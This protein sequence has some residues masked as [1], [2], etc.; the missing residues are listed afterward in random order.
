[1]AEASSDRAAGFSEREF[2][3]RE[4]RGRTL[5]LVVSRADFAE[6]IAPV[7]D[8]LSAGGARAIVVARDAR[9]LER[10]EA[11]PALTATQP[12]LEG[13]VWR[14]LHES[15]R[16]GIVVARGDDFGD[17][18]RELARRLGV[19]KLV[20]LDPAGGLV[21]R[22]G[23]RLSFVHREELAELLAAPYRRLGGKDRLALW[24]EIADMLDAGLPAVN[25]CAPEGLADELFTYAGSGTLFTRERYMTVRALGVD[26][27]DAAHDLLRRGVDEGFLAPRDGAE[28]DA[29]LA[30]GFGAFALG[31]DLA[32]IGALLPSPDG[33]G[34]EVAGL[35]TLTRFLGEGV[36]FALVAHA[37]DEARRRGLTYAF[38]CTTSERVGAFLERNG[39]RLAAHGEVPGAKWEDYDEGRR[40]RVRCFRRDLG[41]APEPAE[42][43]EEDEPAEGS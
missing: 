34:G 29:L 21:T 5:A 2:Y 26:D 30:S 16:I 18:A 1:M 32:G 19:F 7:L 20:W 39:F 6:P 43:D 15:S 10:L 14:A 11:K 37:L 31:R 41:P 24:R 35:Y 3:L 42:N 12:R 4:F 36:G 8:D 17:H 38:A 28:L 25:V 40:A 9:T 23:E 22:R 13:E 27:Y 33:Q